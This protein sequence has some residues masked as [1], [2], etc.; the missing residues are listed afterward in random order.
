MNAP[1]DITDADLKRLDAFLGSE[2]VPESAMDV[3]TLEGFLTALVIG[4]HVV[5]PSAW[6][7]WMWDFERGEQEV[8][9]ADMAQARETMGRIM[10]LMNR[11]AGA[12]ARDPAAFEPV[13][14]R[15]AAWGAAEWCEGFLAATQRFNADDWAALWR[16]DAAGALGAADRAGMIMPF[17]RLGEAS[18]REITREEGNARRWVDAVVPALAAIH[19]HWLARRPTRPSMVTRAP[20]RREA[21]KSGRNDPCPCGSGLKFKKCCGQAPTVH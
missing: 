15:D 13:F 12:F 9:F 10:G 21:P 11:I 19:A 17:L 6:M 20:M 18:G 4:P 2:H 7:P 1:P 14:F 3:A 5:M 16:L 8:E